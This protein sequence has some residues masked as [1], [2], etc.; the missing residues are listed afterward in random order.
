MVVNNNPHNVQVLKAG[1]GGAAYLAR[2]PPL[3]LTPLARVRHGRC[4]HKHTYEYIRI[5]MNTYE[6]YEGRPPYSQNLSFRSK[7]AIC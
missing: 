4:D 2:G 5:S 1:S 3:P 6:Y 7:P